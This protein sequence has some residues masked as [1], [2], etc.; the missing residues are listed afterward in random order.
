MARESVSLQGESESQSK[1]MRPFP[2]PVCA[3]VRSLSLTITI[4]AESIDT[5]LDAS[6]QT[7]AQIVLQ[8]CIPNPFVFICTLFDDP[9]PAVLTSLSSLRFSS[10]YLPLKL[11]NFRFIYQYNC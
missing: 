1:Q 2:P 8:L 10:A 4:V 6:S 9:L 3:G 7:R 11:G 5:Q